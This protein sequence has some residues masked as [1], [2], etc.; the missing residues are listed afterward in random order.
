VRDALALLR[1]WRWA[2]AA[3][4]VVVVVIALAK[5]GATTA[6]GVAAAGAA[7]AAAAARSRRRS[8]VLRSDARAQADIDAAEDGRIAAR[9]A[10]AR[11]AAVETPEVDDA[12][13]LRSS[14]LDRRGRS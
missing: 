2:I 12:E 5:F 11:R 1:R 9:A 8:D 4:V 3:A 14:L 6:A 7:T 13:P 10:R